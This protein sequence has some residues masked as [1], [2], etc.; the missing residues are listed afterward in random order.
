MTAFDFCDTTRTCGQRDVTTVA[1]QALA[2]LNN[3]FI[4]QQS[5]TVA[6]RVAKLA[7]NDLKRQAALAWKLILGREPDHDE[8]AGAVSHLQEQKE[9][10][11]SAA[12]QRTVTPDVT[13][14]AGSDMAIR[15]LKNLS[16]WL[17]ADQGGDAVQ[18]VE[19]KMRIHLCPQRFH[20]QFA[21]GFL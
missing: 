19:N 14:V 8:W 4:H 18:A 9:H 21:Y 10:F 13:Q 7:G 1:P 12:Q 5:D 17:R 2:L 3:E 20:L 15:S 11:T 16:M 6:D